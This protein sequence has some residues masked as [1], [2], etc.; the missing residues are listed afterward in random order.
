[1]NEEI[2]TLIIVALL[3]FLPNLVLKLI[4]KYKTPQ[5]KAKSELEAADLSVDTLTQALEEMRKHNKFLEEK[6][7]QK[8]EEITVQRKDIQDLEEKLKQLGGQ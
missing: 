1:M 6:L 7:N 8:R 3:G 5:E 4:E 2:I